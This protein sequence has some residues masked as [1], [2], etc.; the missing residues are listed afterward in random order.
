MVDYKHYKLTDLID[1]DNLQLNKVSKKQKQLIKD[2]HNSK[3]YLSTILKSIADGVI[4]TDKQGKINRMNKKAEEL[5]GWNFEE[6]EGKP[7]KEI[8]NIGEAPSAI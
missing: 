6:A 1:I 8:F 7:F 5:T 3:E 4:V 2:L